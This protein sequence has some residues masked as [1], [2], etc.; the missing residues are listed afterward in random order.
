V[1]GEEPSTQTFATRLSHLF[2]TVQ[3]PDGKRWSL[4]AVA[5][6]LTDRY[7]LPTTQSYVSQLR[8]G[9]RVNPTINYVAALASIFGVPTS[10]LV[11]NGLDGLTRD[12]LDLISTMRSAG[13]VGIAMRA[14]DVPR[15]S[16]KMVAQLLDSLREQKGLPPV[17]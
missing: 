14:M 11:D 6:T 4:S 5:R 3:G 8:S 16:Q 12:E 15:E 17:K 7:D 10:Y 2:E 13:V 9:A 1:S